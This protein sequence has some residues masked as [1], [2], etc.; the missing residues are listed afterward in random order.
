LSWYRSILIVAAHPDDEVLGCG[1]SIPIWI[2]GGTTVSTLIL[3]EG[4]T[5]RFE[6]RDEAPRHLVDTLAE[7]ARAANASLGVA[8]TSLCEFPDQRLD[9]LALLEVTKR[10]E[11]E[12]AAVKPEAVF[13][14]HGGDLNLDHA[15]TFRAAMAATRPMRGGVV[16]ALLAY[17]VASSSEWSFRQYAPAFSPNTFVDVSATIETKI[18]ALRHYESEL[19]E[20]PHPRSPEALRATAQFWGSHVGLLAAEPFELIWE[21]R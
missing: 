3:G 2:A 21:I 11:K 12:I 5:S 7:R 6:V 8:H 16:R 1:G 20:F 15:L 17:P 4:V 9:T 19:R 18:A 10:I 14:Q 13:V